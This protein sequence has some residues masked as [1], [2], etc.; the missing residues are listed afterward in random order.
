MTVKLDSV[1]GIFAAK[2]V[3]ETVA[4]SDAEIARVNVA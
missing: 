2:K 4:K 1:C 3:G